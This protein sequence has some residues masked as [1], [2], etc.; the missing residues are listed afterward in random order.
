[1]GVSSSKK[2]MLAP[3]SPST[4]Y[5][6][7]IPL[8]DVP[9]NKRAK[10]IHLVSSSKWLS[11]IMQDA[12]KDILDIFIGSREA[13]EDF[14]E[15]IVTKCIIEVADRSNIKILL[16]WRSFPVNVENLALAFGV[17]LC[18]L[19]GYQKIDLRMWDNSSPVSNVSVPYSLSTVL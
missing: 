3:S 6:I 15:V 17:Q 18:E 19:C 2:K 5:S 9:I 12:N 7:G 4:M 13:V 10:L 1:M 11:T 14:P 8:R 16:T